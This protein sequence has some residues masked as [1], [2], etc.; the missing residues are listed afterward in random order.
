VLATEHDRAARSRHQGII[1][2]S[3][4]S[5]TRSIDMRQRK[6]FTLIELLVVISIIALL[7]GILLP[8]LSRARELANR[9][10][11]S[12]NLKGIYQSLYT[13]A[14]SSGGR[15]PMYTTNTTLPAQGLI[16][17]I[18]RNTAN[19][20]AS[21]SLTNNV[22]ASLWI[23]IRQGASVPKS[24]T[25]PSEP[26][27]E[28]DPQTTVNTGNLTYSTTPRPA[29]YIWDFAFAKSLS[30]SA[31]NP[32]RRNSGAPLW[33]QDARPD[34]IIMGDDNSANDANAPSGTPG[35]LHTQVKGGAN[36]N[37]VNT[38]K[39]KENSQNHNQGEGQNF[40]WCDGHI[41]FANDPYQGVNGDNAYADSGLTSTTVAATAQEPS[42]VWDTA[43]GDS[44]S[45]SYDSMLIAV[46]GGSSASKR[47]AP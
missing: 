30:F 3:F 22:T 21:A 10:V 11:C 35:G 12:A 28:A 2:L 24:F 41:E 37:N 36:W 16:S 40:M 17:S 43:F 26:G 46:Q 31:H 45:R 44:G 8:S 27:V 23:L 6:G 7:I 9:A 18:S 38:L 33:G 25:C 4:V 32:Y 20:P 1:P 13:Y 15:Y 47:W 29:N 14:A 19:A 5:R 39:Y 42:K 34:A